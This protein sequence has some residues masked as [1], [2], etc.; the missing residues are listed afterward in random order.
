M[1]PGGIRTYNLSRQA[2]ADLRLRRHGHWDRQPPYM[3]GLKYTVKILNFF[4]FPVC[5]GIFPLFSFV[6]HLSPTQS[7]FRCPVL[8]LTLTKRQKVLVYGAITFVSHLL[9]GCLLEIVPSKP[10]HTWIQKLSL[11]V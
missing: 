6:V 3:L 10:R 4:F 2:A 8:R 9:S 7:H 11:L 1:P 5:I